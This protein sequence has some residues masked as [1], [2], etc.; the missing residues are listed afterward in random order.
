M[1]DK[2]E[3]AQAYTNRMR[4]HVLDSDAELEAAQARNVDLEEQ[5]DEVN[6]EH[7]LDIKTYEAQL[8]TTRAALRTYGRHKATNCHSAFGCQCGLSDALG[9]T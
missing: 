1:T 3:A 4:Q 6:N 5:L 2:T 9:D 8:E 7:M